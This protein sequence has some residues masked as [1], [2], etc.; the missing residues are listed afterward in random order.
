VKRSIRKDKR[1]WINEQAKYAEEAERRG[2]VKELYN[3]TR[4]LSQRKFKMNRPI[5]TK[6]G[7]RLTTQE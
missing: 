2:D 1:H 5:K 7:M 6:S 3:I 4:K